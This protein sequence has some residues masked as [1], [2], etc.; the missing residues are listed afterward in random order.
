MC[1]FIALGFVFSIPCS[2][3]GLGNIPEMTILC[4]VGRKTTTQ[5]IKP[6]LGVSVACWLS[7]SV[8]QLLLCTTS[9]GLK[10]LAKFVFKMSAFGLDTCSQTGASL[11]DCRI[12]NTLVKF[13]DDTLGETLSVK[14]VYMVDNSGSTSR[15]IISCLGPEIC[16]QINRI[17]TTFC[18]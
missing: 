14:A 6:A 13:S 10:L 18:P 11:S 1:A 4:R 17:L 12:N 5:S 7:Q 16:V 9:N 8:C 3:I 2:E 15:S